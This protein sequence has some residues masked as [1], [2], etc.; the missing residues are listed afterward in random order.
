MVRYM[1]RDGRVRARRRDRVR[2]RNISIGLLFLHSC[3][4]SARRKDRDRDRDRDTARNN[5]IGSRYL[6]NLFTIFRRIWYG[7]RSRKEKVRYMLRDG[8]VRAW[9]R[10]RVR[11]RNICI[12]L[13]FL[14][15]CK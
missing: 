1:Q 8:R 13:L 5:S 3:K 4:D 11:D 2:D 9:R 6:S 10:D 7:A 14:H 15:S 12:V